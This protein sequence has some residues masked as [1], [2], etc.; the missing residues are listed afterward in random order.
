MFSSSA[1]K[2]LFV[3]AAVAAS[4]GVAT[5][6]MAEVEGEYRTTTVSYADLDLASEAGVARLNSRIKFAA[7]QVCGIA[8]LDLRAAPEISR[9]REAA[10]EHATRATVTVIAA[11]RRG[12]PY[13]SANGG[14]VAVSS[15]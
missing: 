3:T 10:I 7:R 9:C 11:A 12:E 6:A 1:T 13:A 4:G 5:P 15:R 8:N 14:R 2:A